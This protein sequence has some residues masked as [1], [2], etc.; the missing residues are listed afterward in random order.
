MEGEG[1]AGGRDSRFC[2]KHEGKVYLSRA[3]T[4]TTYVYALPRTLSW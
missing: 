1:G 4:C 2:G 3:D